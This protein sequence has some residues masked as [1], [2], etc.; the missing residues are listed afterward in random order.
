MMAIQ[1]L[2]NNSTNHFDVLPI[3]HISNFDY[4]LVFKS[5]TAPSYWLE[6]ESIF[7]GDFTGKVI[8]DRM[9]HV[10]NSKDRFVIYNVVKGKIELNEK[11]VVEFKRKDPVR[12]QSNNIYR[13]YPDIVENSILSSTQKKLLLHG[14]S[15]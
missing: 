10:G 3:N 11:K 4:L 1:E 5:Y 2:T 8:L 6:V 15:V 14:L 13:K 12:I 7:S 9:L